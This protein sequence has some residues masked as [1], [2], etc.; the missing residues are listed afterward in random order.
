MTTCSGESWTTENTAVMLHAV[1]FDPQGQA[2]PLKMM[3]PPGIVHL[4]H[5]NIKS[6]EM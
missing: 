1:G 4:N 5:I 2:Y 3:L 6:G